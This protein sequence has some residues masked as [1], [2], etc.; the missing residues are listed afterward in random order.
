MCK[1]MCAGTTVHAGWHR[2]G[3]GHFQGW[4]VPAH[5]VCVLVCATRVHA[6][7]CFCFASYHYNV[8]TPVHFTNMLFIFQ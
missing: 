2:R 6:H 4:R 3:W 7:T 5:S 1:V 8:F